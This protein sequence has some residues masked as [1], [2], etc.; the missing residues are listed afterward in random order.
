MKL[1]TT[2]IFQA[3]SKDPAP[4]LC[5]L[6][7]GDIGNIAVRLI[8]IASVQSLEE[9]L[10]RCGGLIDRPNLDQASSKYHADLR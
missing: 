8:R 5:L 2:P 4:L 1:E 10:P 3:M 7:R 6:L 9:D